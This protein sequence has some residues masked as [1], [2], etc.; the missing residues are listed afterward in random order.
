MKTNG[1]YAL[2]ARPERDRL[3]F[4]VL[5][6]IKGEKNSV[7]ARGAVS[8]STIASWRRPLSAG[9]TRYPQALS[10]DRVLRAHGK[11]LGIT[12]NN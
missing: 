9:G 10:L 12:E 7:A 4:E 3:I 2:P 1:R 11:K 5:R 8:P 6:V